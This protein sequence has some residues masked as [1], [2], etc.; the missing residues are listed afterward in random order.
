MAYSS[1]AGKGPSICTFISKLCQLGT[2][3]LSFFALDRAMRPDNP[4]LQLSILGQRARF[5]LEP[6]CVSAYPGL[7]VCLC[8]RS[9]HG[10]TIN[11]HVN[12]ATACCITT[13]HAPAGFLGTYHIS[14]MLQIFLGHA[15]GKKPFES[16]RWPGSS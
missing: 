14:H 6:V 8:S 16:M 12:I 10:C 15:S 13:S 5:L 3:Q 11:E 4:R 2:V 7:D 9:L 1:H